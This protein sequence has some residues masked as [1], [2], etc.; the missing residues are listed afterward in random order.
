VRIVYP[1]PT[2]GVANPARSVRLDTFGPS[3]ANISYPCDGHV[4]TILVNVTPP[5][6]RGTAS[7]GTPSAAFPT[8]A[9]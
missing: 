7:F 9:A 2:P 4:A 1:D 3:G 5:V 6:N 8:L